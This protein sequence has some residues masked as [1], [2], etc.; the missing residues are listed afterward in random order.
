[1]AG[2]NYWPSDLDDV[3]PFNSGAGRL[4]FGEVTKQSLSR[5]ITRFKTKKL[6]EWN[7]EDIVDW[8]LSTCKENHIES[9]A[10]NVVGFAAL[11]G[12][13]LAEI[14]EN[15]VIEI[16]PMYG[17]ELYMALRPYQ[18]FKT[19]GGRLISQSSGHN[20]TSDS[21][22]IYFDQYSD[23]PYVH[24]SYG[25]DSYNS[26]GFLSDELHSLSVDS[27][28]ES[29]YSSSPC[30]LL[31]DLTISSHGGLS[32]SP[33]YPSYENCHSFNSRFDY[34]ADTDGLGYYPGNPPLA[35]LRNEDLTMLDTP[36]NLDDLTPDWDLLGADL[37]GP[38]SS[39]HTMNLRR[40]S[41]GKNPANLDPQILAA[42]GSAA[43]TSGDRRHKSGSSTSRS[44]SPCKRKS[45]RAKMA[46]HG[47]HVRSVTSG[48]PRE[49]GKKVWE[50]LLDLLNNPAT[51]P[52]M[53]KWENKDEGIFR[54]VEHDLIAQ[55]WG[56]RRDR[57][58]LSYDY[59]A[60][61]MRYQYTTGML[62]SVP[63]RKLVFRFGPEVMRKLQEQP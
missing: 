46:Q 19:S 62:E 38:S 21:P 28:S 33:S 56:A 35:E 30:R 47:P 32:S 41:S 37:A 27:S 24:D 18:R 50:F 25:N 16:E 4:N 54:L 59:F 61:T 58:D 10:V 29:Y 3:E 34:S 45:V 13:H 53:I 63:E 57:K 42:C 14:T 26:S 31:E 8:V 15:Q 51:N 40:V 55:R 17:R 2:M 9:E 43:S 44:V 48:K 6:S 12:S 23:S 22:H 20:L 49:R 5:M 39:H 11:T 36:E 1:M 7:R 52:S 60:R